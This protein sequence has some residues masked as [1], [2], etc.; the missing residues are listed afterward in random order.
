M[1]TNQ[2]VNLNVNPNPFV[3]RPCVDVEMPHPSFP[4]PPLGK[5]GLGTA[6]SNFDP[7]PPSFAPSSY[8]CFLAVHTEEQLLRGGC[9]YAKC[10]S[11]ERGGEGEDASGAARAKE[12]IENLVPFFYLGMRVTSLE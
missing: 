5:G 3:S 12:R 6:A 1:A 2:A 10:F 7:L 11:S 8:S 9:F 4:P